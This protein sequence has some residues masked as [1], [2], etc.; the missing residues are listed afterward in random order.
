MQEYKMK[1]FH[2][3]CMTFTKRGNPTALTVCQLHVLSVTNYYL[4]HWWYLKLSLNSLLCDIQIKAKTLTAKFKI[5]ISLMGK[6][7]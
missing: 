3:P 6:V 5:I 4:I 2:E 1:L 7:Y